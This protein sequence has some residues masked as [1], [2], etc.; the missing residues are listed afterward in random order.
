MIVPFHS[1]VSV[2]ASTNIVTLVALEMAHLGIR[3]ALLD[4]DLLGGY[5]TSLL[6]RRH[7]GPCDEPTYADVLHG[8]AP[9]TAAVRA[10]PTPNLFVMPPGRIAGPDDMDGYCAR[11]MNQVRFYEQMEELSAA[12]DVILVALQDRVVP[13]S[14]YVLTR[15]QGVVAVIDPSRRDVRADNLFF[16]HRSNEPIIQKEDLLAV[17]PFGWELD[18][19]MTS[20]FA[21]EFGALLMPITLA[22]GFHECAIFAGLPLR[23]VDPTAQSSRAVTQNTRAILD[24]IAQ[25]TG[26]SLVARGEPV[27]RRPLSAA[28]LVSLRNE[29][30]SF[31]QEE[32]KRFGRAAGAHLA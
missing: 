23:L 12:F 22:E 3:T 24:R 20:E 31:I 14:T 32:L 10:T 11:R 19:T 18:G 21:E 2:A 28:D 15:S 4:L 25:R 7:G 6:G 17:L 9:L 27:E 29:F 26:C 5:A 13:Q 1:S 8:S 30:T 16:D